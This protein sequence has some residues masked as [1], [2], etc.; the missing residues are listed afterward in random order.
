VLITSNRGLCGAYNAQAIKKAIS[1][2]KGENAGVEI[3]TIGKKGDLAMR[4]VGANVIANFFEL[5]DN[6]SLRDILPISKMLT[7]D[8]KVANTIRSTSFIPILFRLSPNGRIQNKFC[9]FPRQS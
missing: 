8:F 7:N 1:L 4:R 5:S 2:L 3:I 9:R 6:L